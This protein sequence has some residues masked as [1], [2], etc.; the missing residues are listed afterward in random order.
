V[1]PSVTQLKNF[2]NEIPSKVSLLSAF[3]ENVK[4]SFILSLETLCL[5]LS[6]VLSLDNN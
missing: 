5:T 3:L 1:S 6:L 2:Q 4:Y